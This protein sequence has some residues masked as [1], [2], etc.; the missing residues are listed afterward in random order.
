[1]TL[2]NLKIGLKVQSF[3]VQFQVLQKKMSKN[4]QYLKYFIVNIR[5]HNLIRN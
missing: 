5:I 3:I 4:Y 2:K 1:M